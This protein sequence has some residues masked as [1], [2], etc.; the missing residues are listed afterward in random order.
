MVSTRNMSRS[1]ANR[2]RAQDQQ[3]NIGN[4]QPRD[5]L[6]A[7]QAANNEMEALCLINQ[8]LLRELVELTR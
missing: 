6:E 1:H 4:I 2:L 5:A 3:D 7:L 8:R